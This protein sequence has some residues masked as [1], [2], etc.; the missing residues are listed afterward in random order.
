MNSYTICYATDDNYAQHVAVS[1]VSLFLNNTEVEKLN[2]FILSNRLSIKN[3]EIIEL[4]AEKYNRVITF[5]EVDNIEQLIG[6][7]V[8]V[9]KLSISTYLRLFLADFMPKDVDKLLYLDCDVVIE[10]SIAELL[11]I[12]MCS[13]YVGGVQDTM[14]PSYYDGVG[15]SLDQNYINAG[16]LLI[17]LKKWREENITN[18]FLQFIEKFNGNVPHLDQGVINGVFQEKLILDLKYNVQTPLFIFKKYKDIIEFFELTNYYPEKEWIRA[19]EEPKIIHYSS[20]YAQRPWFKFCLHPK[21]SRYRYY[22][23]LTP[24]CDNELQKNKISLKGKIKSLLMVNCQT[25]YLKVRKV[26]G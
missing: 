12:D 13:Y 4:T 14:F 19:V 3:K 18:K 6:T 5:I 21:R 10:S 23:S 26:N 8:N 24:Y 17:N 15:L 22:K 11:K 25:L 7:K 16:V 2:V 1:I 9:N 20:S